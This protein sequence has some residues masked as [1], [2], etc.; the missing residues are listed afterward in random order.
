[1][2]IPELN[3]FIVFDFAQKH[4]KYFLLFYHSFLPF[5]FFQTYIL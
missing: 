1:M 2:A 4:N 5:P 3:K